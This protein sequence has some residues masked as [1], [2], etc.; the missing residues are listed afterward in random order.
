MTTPRKR[1]TLTVDVRGLK[2]PIAEA[3]GG[4]PSPWVRSLIEAALQAPSRP[5]T[6]VSPRRPH[7]NGS[8]LTVW[9]STLERQALLEGA[10]AEG[11]SQAEYVGRLATSRNAG[12]A[13]IGH[14]A[15]KRLAE[16]NLQLVK[17]GVNLNQI[18]R[19]LN[20]MGQGAPGEFKDQDRERI[21][22]AARA[23]LDHVELVASL[24]DHLEVTRRK[25]GRRRR[26]EHAN[27]HQ[28]APGPRG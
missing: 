14:E 27:D 25:A 18:A 20:A 12:G 3:S 7:D 10:L 2:E 28:H 5:S 22:A 4:Q 21:E 9:L 13:F 15:L 26:A 6:R 1:E 23:A 16:S 8:K 24:I 17:I 11:L 19:A